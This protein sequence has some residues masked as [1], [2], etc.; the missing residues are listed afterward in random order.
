MTPP[1]KP[2][3]RGK[4]AERKRG[5]MRGSVFLSE[6]KNPFSR[7]IFLKRCGFFLTLFLKMTLF[8]IPR[9]KKAP[10]GGEQAEISDFG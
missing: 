2:S 4:V 6:A 1:P 5:R 7:Q 8:L 9:M 3:P 10:F